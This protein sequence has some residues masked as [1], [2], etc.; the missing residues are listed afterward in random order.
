MKEVSGIQG[1]SLNLSHLVFNRVD[2]E[3]YHIAR[4]LWKDTHDAAAVYAIF[5][6]RGFA[7]RKLLSFYT[8]NPGQHAKAIKAVR[9]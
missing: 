5:P 6:K 9:S 8:R 2:R 3:E 7:E 4:T 1:Y